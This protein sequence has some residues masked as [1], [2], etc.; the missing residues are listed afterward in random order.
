MQLYSYPAPDPIRRILPG[1][2]FRVES[3]AGYS[4]I[5]QDSIRRFQLEIVNRRLCAVNDRF[6]LLRHIEDRFHADRMMLFYHL[7]IDIKTITSM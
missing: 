3:S 1:P 2:M 7:K 6:A 5:L 4:S